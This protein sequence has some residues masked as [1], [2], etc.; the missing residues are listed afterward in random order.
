M[1]HEKKRNAVKRTLVKQDRTASLSVVYWSNVY[2]SEG[3]RVGRR[4]GSPRAGC[5]A[6][7][8]GPKRPIPRNQHRLC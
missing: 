7:R 2:S 5:R 3:G 1:M 6:K 4:A 8:N